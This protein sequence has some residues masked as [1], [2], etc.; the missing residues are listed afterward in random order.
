M[1]LRH[2]EIHQVV[3]DLEEIQTAVL[4]TAGQTLAARLETPI[5]SLKMIDTAINARIKHLGEKLVEA[6]E[7]NRSA[8]QTRDREVL[9]AKAHRK[10]IQ[11]ARQLV[12]AL[13][14]SGTIP[15]RE[16]KELNAALDLGELN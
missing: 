5:E 8:Q 2:K 4:S 14:L 6:S 9:Q 11:Q 1:T 16:A 7:R 15:E 3:K 13:E 10:A 12:K